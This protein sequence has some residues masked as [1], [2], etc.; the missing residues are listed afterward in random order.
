MTDLLLGVSPDHL[1][2]NQKKIV[3]VTSFHKPYFLAFK[4][5]ISET[6]KAK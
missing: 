2:Y 6:K 4:K 5:T 3:D 1:F